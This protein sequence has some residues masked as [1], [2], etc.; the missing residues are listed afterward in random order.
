M[1]VKVD[2]PWNRKYIRLLP[3]KI[4]KKYMF[5]H[6]N[7][8]HCCRNMILSLFLAEYEIGKNMFKASPSGW[9]HDRHKDHISQASASTLCAHLLRMLRFALH[10]L[11]SQ[12]A[13]S[14]MSQQIFSSHAVHCCESFLALLLCQNSLPPVSWSHLHSEKRVPIPQGSLCW[15]VKCFRRLNS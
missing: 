3:A 2:S 6:V 15:C 13:F 4:S 9:N 8:I 14:A 5:F 11:I 10:A 12:E 1:Q 7:K